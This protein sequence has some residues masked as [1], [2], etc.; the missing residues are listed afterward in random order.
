MSEIEIS[1]RI[2]VDK[3]GFDCFVLRLAL[4]LGELSSYVC[5][6]S[7]SKIS[8]SSGRPWTG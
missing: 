7:H 3:I 6:D 5:D 4:R 1:L 2:S 8:S